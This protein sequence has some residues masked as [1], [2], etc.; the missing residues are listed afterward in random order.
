MVNWLPFYYNGRP[1]YKAYVCISC[2]VVFDSEI[3]HS[4]NSLNLIKSAVYQV[5][6]LWCTSLFY[7]W[8][9]FLWSVVF[10][11]PLSAHDLKNA[12]WSFWRNI[13]MQRIKLVMKR[14]I[15]NFTALH[16]RNFDR[17]DRL[18]KTGVDLWPGMCA[19]LRYSKL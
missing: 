10:K 19:W 1:E 11:I 13:Y 8:Q 12:K 15:L 3:P 7:C 18:T 2:V 9:H 16:R 6:L 5:I 4:N 14:L 17:G